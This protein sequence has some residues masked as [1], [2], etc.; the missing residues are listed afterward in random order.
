MKAFGAVAGPQIAAVALGVARAAIDA[1]Q[2]L[3]AAKVPHGGTS[4]LA[5]QQTVHE[6][7]GRAEALVR[8]A[9]AYYYETVRELASQLEVRN[10]VDDELSARV[11]LACAHTAQSAQEAVDL[12]FS[13]GGIS[14]TYASSPLD[15]SFRD[16]H[17]VTQHVAVAASN[18][19]MVG[20]YLL[21]HRLQLRR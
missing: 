6:R 7:V 9:R 18:I 15:R 17:M 16:A 10:E 20:Q 21:G 14:A 19:E 11:R 4:V 5:S 1:F 2:D 3:A 12:M 13:A 8:S